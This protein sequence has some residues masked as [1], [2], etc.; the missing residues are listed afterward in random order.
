MLRV[1]W[2][3]E[4]VI[5]WESVPNGR[6]VDAEFYCQHLER[7]Y[8]NLRR[9]YSA[10]VNR[11]RVLLQQGNA[12]PHTAKTSMIQRQELRGIR[13]L[14]QPAYIPDLAPSV[15]HFFDPWLISC[16]EDISKT[17]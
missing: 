11:N 3:F 9:R 10:L 13:L 1:W 15:Y 7:L 17:W 14:P 2:N 12:T 16:V 5:H 6:A 8:E 4:G